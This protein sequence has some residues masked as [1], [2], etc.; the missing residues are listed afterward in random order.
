MNNKMNH[1]FPVSLKAM[2]SPNFNDCFLFLYLTVLKLI[3]NTLLFCVEFQK[4]YK[5][6]TYKSHNDLKILFLAVFWYY[7]NFSHAHVGK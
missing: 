7:F 4:L 1:D 6:N 2:W 3:T 5:N